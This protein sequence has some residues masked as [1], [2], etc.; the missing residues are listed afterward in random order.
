LDAEERKETRDEYEDKPEDIV[1]SLK[2]E[3]LL[4]DNGVYNPE[5][6]YRSILR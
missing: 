6:P 4:A 1:K 3:E 5:S 2:V